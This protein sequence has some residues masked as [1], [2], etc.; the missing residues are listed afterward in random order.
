M[1]ELN[2]TPEK[3]GKKLR[4]KK[5]AIRVDLTAMVDLAFLL[6]TFFILTTTLA[7]PKMMKITM[8]VDNTEPAPQVA[9]RSMTICL[10]KNDQAVW[11]LGTADEPLVPATVAGYGKNG[12]RRAIANMRKKVLETTGKTLLV[13]VKPS[14]RSV[15]EN[16]V[17]TIDELTIANIDQYTIADID[18]KD[19]SML[20]NKRAY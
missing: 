13:L 17:D 3:T 5:Q 18:A 11:Y 2:T 8:P 16:L 14:D 1:A 4:S 19:I 15:Y 9:S 12:L 10:G 7:K 6:I 20:K